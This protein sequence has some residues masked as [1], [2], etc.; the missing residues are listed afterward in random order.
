MPLS[1]SSLSLAK[2]FRASHDLAVSPPDAKRPTGAQSAESVPSV[3]TRRRFTA[4]QKLRIIEEADACERGQLGD[5][6]RKHGI[7]HSHLVSWRDQLRRHGR[8]GMAAQKPGPKPSRDAKDER[9]A[10][11]E[12]KLARAEKKLSVAAS[13]IEFQK[14]VSVMLGVDL[15]ETSDER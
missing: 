3:R 12:K 8:E 9:I 6:L 4:E 5:V 11:L 7:Y 10:E 15:D 14:K 13:V 2:G 1:S